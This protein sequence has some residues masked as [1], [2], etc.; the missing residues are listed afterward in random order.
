MRWLLVAILGYASLVIQTAVFRPGGLALPIDGHWTR[1]DLV[2]ILGLFLALYF[3]PSEVFVA[4]WCLGMAADLVTVGGTLGMY[5]LLFCGVLTGLS[6]LRENLN[7]RWILTQ[8]VLCFA[9]VLVTHLAWYQAARYFAGDP[10]AILRSVEE[11][12]LDAAYAA[13]LAPYVIWL[14]MRLRGPLGVTVEPYEI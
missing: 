11:S 9:A 13:I 5:A 2:L 3:R 8:S 1:P 6:Y 4:G 7:R 10:P 14:L 12:V